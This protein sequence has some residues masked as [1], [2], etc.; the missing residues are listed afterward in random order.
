MKEM[1]I[2]VLTTLAFAGCESAPLQRVDSTATVRP[3]ISEISPAQA[4]PAVEAAYSQLVDVREPAEF[5][6]GHAYRARNIPLATLAENL[7]KIEKNEPVYLICQTDNRSRQAADILAKAGFK[8][9]IV[10]TGGTVAWKAAG[11]PMGDEAP[12]VLSTKLDE[13]TANALLAALDDERRAAATYEAVLAKFPGVRP[14]VNIVEAEKQHQALLLPM[15]AK[16]GVQVPK[17]EFDASSIA[18]PE[19]LAEAC[20]AAIKAEEDNIALYDGF[21]EF[22]KEADIK[23]I[24]ERLQAA[25]RDNHLPAFTRCATGGGGPGPGRGLGRG[26]PN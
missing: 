5:A 8:S 21:F 23:A 11:L 12:A 4:R 9:V 7:D 22:I 16:Y 18:V 14:F 10:V 13:R 19:T 24:F 25:S 17:N 26:R 20:K 6:A 15:F 2:M 1:I 3:G